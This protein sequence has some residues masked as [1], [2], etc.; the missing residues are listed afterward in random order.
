MEARSM[1]PTIPMGSKVTVDLDA[2]KQT[3]IER[4]DIVCFQS[5]VDDRIWAFRVAGLPGEVV[6]IEDGNLMIDGVAVE[7]DPIEN[8]RS[9]PR[10]TQ[11]ELESDMYF[12]LGDNGTIAN[13]SRMIGPIPRDR[14]IGKIKDIQQVAAGNV[15]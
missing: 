15:R 3:E 11:M 7:F 6:L 10:Y 4:G 9:K 2:Y 1:E 12:L 8:P 14:I 13:D 5:I